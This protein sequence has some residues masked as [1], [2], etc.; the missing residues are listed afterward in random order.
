MQQP[1]NKN[2]NIYKYKYSTIFIRKI[3]SLTANSIFYIIFYDDDINAVM[4]L[5]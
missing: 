4:S 1:Q 5:N 3:E 2:K